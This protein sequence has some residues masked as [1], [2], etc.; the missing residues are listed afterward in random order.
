MTETLRSDFLD[1]H[2]SFAE[3]I[4]GQKLAENV[5]YERYK[6][7]DVTNQRWVEL[8]G[9]DVNNLTHLTLTYGLTRSLSIT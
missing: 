2:L 4:H 7:D 6:P 3:T 1:I 5:R 9:A 8:L